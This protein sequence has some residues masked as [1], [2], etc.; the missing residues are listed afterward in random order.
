MVLLR[1]QSQFARQLRDGDQLAARLHNASYRG[2]L[3]LRGCVANRLYRYV[4]FTSLSEQ[5][6]Y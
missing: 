2:F 3:W 6:K 1:S 5:C 4:G